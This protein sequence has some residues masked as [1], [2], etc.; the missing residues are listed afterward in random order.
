MHIA[1]TSTIGDPSLPATWSS[2]PYNL[3][4]ALNNNGI[5]VSPINSRVLTDF[6]KIIIAAKN[7]MSGQSTQDISRFP[8]GR[9][10]MGDYVAAQAASLGVDNILCCGSMDAPIG[11]DIPY[12][13]WMDDSWDLLCNSLV[14]PNMKSRSKIFIDEVERQSLAGAR[15]IFTFSDHVR[16]NII[17]HYKIAAEKV[18]S[19]G[20]G[21]GPLPALKHEKNYAEGHLLFV[22]KHQFAM[23]GGDLLLKA[24]P[25]IK[26]RR[27]QTKLILVGNQDACNKAQN[28][29]G[30]EVHNFV[31]REIL[32][33]MFYDAS[34]LVQ[35]MLCDPWGQVYLEAMKAQ[36]IVVSLNHRALPQLTDNGR[37]AVLID[38]AE[39]E[40]LA[41]AVLDTYDLPQNILAAM[42]KEA[43]QN[44]ESNYSWD[45]VASRIIK[46]LRS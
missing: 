19:V 38:K 45:N 17:S 34:M 12:S 27:R 31:D 29:E 30:I 25:I 35:P 20:C 2:A 8:A 36:A 46:I 22:A 13:I 9:K 4:Q 44:V 37:L 23:K 43:M 7:I 5:N 16:D 32:N 18:H 6:D 11:H 40:I 14:P 21:S 39:P 41:Q 26:A 10:K 1:I 15:H 28:M 3:S 42:A 24:W 33:T